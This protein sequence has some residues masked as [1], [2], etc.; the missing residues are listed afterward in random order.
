MT[1]SMENR[2]SFF[3]EPESTEG[4]T[5]K[6]LAA[7]KFRNRIKYGQEG[8][9][10][11][12]GFPLIG[13]ATQLGYKYGLAPFVKTTASI[14]AKGVDNAVFRPISYIASRDAVA[15]VV[16]NT[17]KAVRNATNF[18]LTKILAPSIVSAFSGKFVRQLPPFEQW[19]LRSLES[20][21]KEE[22]VI[23]RL[24]NILSYFRSFGKMPKDI[25]LSARQFYGHFHW[26]VD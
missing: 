3:F 12:G 6:E 22:R 10:V 14:G 8:L 20:P 19:R 25:G 16:K 21:I 23:R 26:H 7:A 18:T 4:L 11:G 2:E 24:D 17:S 1:C 9:A 15:P 5:G 13:K